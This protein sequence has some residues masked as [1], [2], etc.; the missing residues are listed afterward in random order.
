MHHDPFDTLDS[1]IL[2]QIPEK[3]EIITDFLDDA[4]FTWG[5]LADE[6]KVDHILSVG[7]GG[8]VHIGAEFPW[9]H[10]SMG[11]SEGTLGLE[12][13]S[14]NF[15]LNHEFGLSRDFQIDGLTPNHTERFSCKSSC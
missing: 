10:M 6:G 4:T 11:F 1:N 13:L 7:D 12:K 9:M 5:K 3:H 14:G 2:F 8:H 15:S